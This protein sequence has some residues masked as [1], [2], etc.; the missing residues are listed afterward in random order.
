M[1]DLLGKLLSHDRDRCSLTAAIIGHFQEVALN[2]AVIPLGVAEAL[3]GEGGFGHA[4]LLCWKAES[5]IHK[6]PFYTL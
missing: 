2:R 6:A 3:E 5:G 4:D 1:S